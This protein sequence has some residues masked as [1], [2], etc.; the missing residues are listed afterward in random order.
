MIDFSGIISDIQDYFSQ[1]KKRTLVLCAI[2]VFMTV[3]A[4]VILSR[5]MPVPGKEKKK[6]QRTLVLD[7][8]LV[9]PKGPEI[10]D[11]YITA[12][13]TKDKWDDEEIKEWFT[14]PDKA[15][16]DNL[17]SSNDRIIEDIIGA[18]P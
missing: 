9:P 8:S 18:A 7:E 11:G 1:N 16:L 17:A 15:E 4:I 2:L 14:E 12:R 3:S 13:T 5:T 6:A 10:P